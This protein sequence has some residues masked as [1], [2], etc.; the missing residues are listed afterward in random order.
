MRACFVCVV[1]WQGFRFLRSLQNL[2]LNSNALTSLGDITS[3]ASLE[4]L[5]VND[6]KIRSLMG[7]A[8]LPNL[9]VC[10]CVVWVCVDVWVYALGP[11]GNG[12]QRYRGSSSLPSVISPALGLGAPPDLLLYPPPQHM[13]TSC[14]P[15]AT[16]SLPHHHSCMCG[17]PCF[18]ALIPGAA[19]CQQ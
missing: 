5:Q 10:G 9:T 16:F 1:L 8:D 12:V 13:R 6:N 2:L 15:V 11:W 4:T 17:T 19:S 7:V 3:V 14:S 18:P